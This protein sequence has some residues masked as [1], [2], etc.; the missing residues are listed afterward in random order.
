MKI[1]FFLKII[2]FQEQDILISYEK[3]YEP[4]FLKNKES[5]NNI[6]KNKE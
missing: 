6:Q 2:L 1:I 3:Q 4:L 5:K